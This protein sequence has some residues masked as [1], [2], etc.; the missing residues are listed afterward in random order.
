MTV[1]KLERTGK[2]GRWSVFV[3]GGFV[4]SLDEVDLLY[5]KLREGD[6]ISPAR[7]EYLRDQIV[8]AKASQKALDFLSRRPRTVNEIEKK[9]SEEYAPDI[10]SRVMDMLNEYK[11]IDDAAY[12]LEYAKE[13]MKAGYGPLKIE[14]EMREKGIS[15]EL[16]EAALEPIKAIQIPT[17]IG[18]L[19]AKYRNKPDVDEK[20]KGRAFNYLQRRG[21][22][23]DISDEALRAFMEKNG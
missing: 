3:D 15:Q 22:E 13:R 21:F 2:R 8:C 12:A 23:T 9:L 16:I 18:A 20:E 11:Y 6:E 14:W 1:T 5:Y 19:R 4:F 10:I 17:A 7:L